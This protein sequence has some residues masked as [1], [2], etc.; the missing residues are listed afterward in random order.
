MVGK[1]WKGCDIEIIPRGESIYC[2]A[3]WANHRL[4]RSIINQ[5]VKAWQADG[6]PS[7]G[8][9]WMPYNDAH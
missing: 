4:F 6:R 3:L 7:Y 1:I 8:L 9:L 5:F 2:R